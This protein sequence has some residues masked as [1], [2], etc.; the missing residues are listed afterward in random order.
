[1]EKLLTGMVFEYGF[2]P[3]RSRSRTVI[4]PPA[5]QGHP[6]P[7]PRTV[8]VAYD[9]GTQHQFV[10]RPGVSYEFAKL[11]S[12]YADYQFGAFFN[13]RDQLIDQRFS[14]GVEY[15]LLENLLMRAGPSMDVRGNVGFSCGASVFLSEWASVEVG[16]QYNMLPELRPEFGRSQTIQA[17]LA[18]RF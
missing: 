8:Q 12:V 1:M 16:Y 14:A 17:A 13:P 11:S 15:R 2:Q 3:Y 7:I 10:L 6:L 4:G 5:I 18:L 9:D